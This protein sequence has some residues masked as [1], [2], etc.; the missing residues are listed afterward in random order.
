VY[1]PARPRPP[2]PPRGRYTSPATSRTELHV[3]PVR[4]RLRAGRVDRVDVR[5]AAGVPSRPVVRPGH[6][7]PLPDNNSTVPQRRRGMRAHGRDKGMFACRLSLVA[8]RL[9]L[10]LCLRPGLAPG[11]RL[12]PRSSSPPPPHPWPGVRDNGVPGRLRPGRVDRVGLR[13][14]PVLHEEERLGHRHPDPRPRHRHPGRERR[15]SMPGS[16]G[17][18]AALLDQPMPGALHW[19][20]ACCRADFRPNA[21]AIYAPVQVDCAHSDWTGWSTCDAVSNCVAGLATA[22]GMCPLSSF[23]APAHHGAR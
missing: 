18:I 10:V 8:C 3:R 13:R 12:M 4:G 19:G 2:I 20:F 16:A 5:R 9:S 23:I 14:Q 22:T 17:G 6:K 11:L 7:H 1:L 21:C 15:A